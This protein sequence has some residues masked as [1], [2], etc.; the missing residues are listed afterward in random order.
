[1]VAKAGMP[2][3]FPFVRPAKERALPM[4]AKASVWDPSRQAFLTRRAAAVARA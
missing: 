4:S 1:M 3:P 2:A